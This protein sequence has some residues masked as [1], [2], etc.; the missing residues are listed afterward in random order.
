MRFRIEFDND[1]TYDT[2]SRYQF[3][4]DDFGSQKP[5]SYMIKDDFVIIAFTDRVTRK[6]PVRRLLSITE[7]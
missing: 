6:I 4:D 5:G 3:S 1:E 2:E 7:K